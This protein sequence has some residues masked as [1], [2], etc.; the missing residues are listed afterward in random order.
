M[1]DIRSSWKGSD[2]HW[3]GSE[4]HWKGSE[5]QWKGSE[6]QWKGATSM[7]STGPNCCSRASAAGSSALHRALMYRWRQLPVPPMAAAVA[8]GLEAFE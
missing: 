8:A 5:L 4:L 3:K 7:L 6:L 1:R 2:L